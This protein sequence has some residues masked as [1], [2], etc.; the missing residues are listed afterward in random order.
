MCDDIIRSHKLGC[1]RVTF[2]HVCKETL[3][4]GTSAG[5]LINLTV[6]QLIDGTMNKLTG[7]SLQIKGLTFGHA[8]PVRFILSTD[9]TTDDGTTM[10]TLVFTIGDGF[11]D[12]TNNDETLGKD[13]PLSHLI[14]WQI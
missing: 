14:V 6:G 7:N 10:K 12:F 2:L 4:I 8:G 3:W 11:E 9:R 1:L 5:V 13:D